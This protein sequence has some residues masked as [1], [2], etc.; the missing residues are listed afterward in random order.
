VQSR[1]K[2]TP[3]DIVI[4]EKGTFKRDVI[5]PEI[6]SCEQTQTHILFLFN[7]GEMEFCMHF[8]N[9]RNHN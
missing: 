5:S 4:L 7:F 8:V 1:K 6:Y 9:D 3:G 2:K